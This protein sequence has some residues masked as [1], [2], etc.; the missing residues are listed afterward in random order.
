MTRWRWVA[1]GC[2]VTAVVVIGSCIVIWQLVAPQAQQFARDVLV[3]SQLELAR[4]AY[5][6][7]DF[8]EALTLL[9]ELLA[10]HPD[11]GAAHNLRALVLVGTDELDEA[12]A[13]ATRAV[14]LAP[15]FPTYD[16][17]AYVHL[18]RR[19]YAAALTSTERLGR[20]GSRARESYYYLL[21]HGLALAGLGRADEA[22]THLRDGLTRIDAEGEQN[23]NWEP[24]PQTE[25]LN[26]MAETALDALGGR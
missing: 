10:E 3:E 21:G 26:D 1:V 24:D 5:R 23:P 15:G 25:D 19:D 18:K 22:R 16:T 4:Q 2:G 17:L 6:D 14:A 9:D 7:Y 11:S 12:L 13:A 8:D 20:S